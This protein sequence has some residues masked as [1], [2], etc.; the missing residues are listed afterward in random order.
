V[1]FNPISDLS[2]LTG[3]PLT[4]L[5]CKNTKISDLSPLKGLPLRTLI[6]AHTRVTDLSPLMGMKLNILFIFGC[7]IADLSPLRGMPLK[8]LRCN[9][10]QVDRLVCAENDAAS[11]ISAKEQ[12]RRFVEKMKALNPDWD[13]QVKHAAK[14]T[15]VLMLKFSTVGVTTIAPVS[16]F[17]QLQ[18]TVL[19][20][21][22]TEEGQGDRRK[23]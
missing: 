4:K 18:E 8:L 12:L 3:M 1:V 6:A 5:M 21:S 16:E 15:K 20:S 13:G 22:E 2:P 10:T 14:G 7:P 11:D 9:G 19:F 23:Q 17:K